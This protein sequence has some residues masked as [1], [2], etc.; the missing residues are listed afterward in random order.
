MSKFK[1]FLVTLVVII[2]VLGGCSSEGDAT[3]DQSKA[4]QSEENENAASDNEK[5]EEILTVS[6]T[7]NKGEETVT[8]KEIEIEDEAILYDVMKENFEIED[9]AGYIT[10]IEGIEAKESEQM[11]WMFF[12]NDEM[13]SKGAK[14]TKLS[15]GDTVNFDLQA[16][17]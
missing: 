14:D 9:D 15:P 2:G 3:N 5:Q 6:I 1:F 12:V 11:A 4:T 7:K 16:W 8:E 13:A 17:E 10:S